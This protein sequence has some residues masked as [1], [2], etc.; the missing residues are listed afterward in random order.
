MFAPPDVQRQY[1]DCH[2]PNILNPVCPV[3]TEFCDPLCY[4]RS[5]TTMTLLKKAH[6]VDCGAVFAPPGAQRQYPDSREP[7]IPSPLNRSD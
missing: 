5:F 1:L 3:Y 6:A 7:D 4:C 2:E